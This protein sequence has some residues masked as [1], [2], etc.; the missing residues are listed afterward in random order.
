[1]DMD[2]SSAYPHHWLSFSLSNNYHHGL[3]EALSTTS[4]PPLGEEGPAEGA[5][6]MEDFLGGL[7]GGGGA[8]AAAP[9][10]APED[11]L[12]C[13]ELGSIAAGFLRRYP[14]PENA[15]G[16]TIAM[17]TDAA[18]ELA[19]PARRTAE[20]FGQRTSIYRGVTRDVGYWENASGTGGRGGTR[21]TCGTI[22]AAGKAKA[23]KA[24]KREYYICV[25]S[26]RKNSTTPAAHDPD[27]RDEV[28]GV[29]P[30]IQEW[31]GAPPPP[32]G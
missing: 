21:R 31:H 14:A 17:A 29:V 23:A 10:A 1:M 11:Q 7:G 4:A 2:M 20:T 15:G 32:D 6:K 13:G 18:A 3:L 12:S 25:N 22:A 16:V 19:D 9:A 5:P 28:L 30:E 24:A 27:S 26:L 8:V